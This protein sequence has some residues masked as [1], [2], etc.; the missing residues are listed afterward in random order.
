MNNNDF[1]T[2]NQMLE[3]SEYLKAE[4]DK[5]KVLLNESVKTGVAEPTEIHKI[6]KHILTSRE[7]NLNV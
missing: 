3:Y 1:V 5:V 2:K 6:A 7:N 4:L